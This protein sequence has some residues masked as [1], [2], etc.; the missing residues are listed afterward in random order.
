MT[1]ALPP[2]RRC[3]RRQRLDWLIHYRPVTRLGGGP[4]PM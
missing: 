4:N 1:E 3:Q 2:P